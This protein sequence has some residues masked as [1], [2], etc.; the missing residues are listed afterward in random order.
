MK[1]IIVISALAVVS[2]LLLLSCRS[3]ISENKKMNVLFIAIDDL[4]PELGIYGIGQVKSPNIDK[5]SE[6]GMVFNRAYCQEAICS[7]S[8][9]SL[10]TGM[11]CQ[12]TKIYGIK[13]KKKDILPEVTS[14]PK[15]FKDN[16]YNTISIGK[17]YHH[18]DDDP[19]AWSKKPYR[20]M[21]G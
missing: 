4:R 1:K 12:S 20:A 19:E 13:L 7:A 18:G 14:L 3:K 15:H 2:T 5:L 8:R 17:I 16:G 21:E 10:L 9:I 6:E 11:Y